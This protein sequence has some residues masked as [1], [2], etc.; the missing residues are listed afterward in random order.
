VAVHE[1]DLDLSDGGSMHEGGVATR[2]GLRG[3]PTSAEEVMVA[4][5]VLLA[6][7]TGGRLHICHLSTSI[8]F[9]LVRRRQL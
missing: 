1:E 7:L 4:R 6:E 3:I 5:D 2:I 9:D 8:G